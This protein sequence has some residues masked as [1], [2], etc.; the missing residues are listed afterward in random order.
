MSQETVMS[1]SSFL[2]LI[3]VFI[4]FYFMLIRPQKKRE[5]E[6]QMMRKNLEVGDEIVTVGGIIGTI[7]SVKED[8]DYLVI[9]TSADR[10]KVRITRWAVQANITPKEKSDK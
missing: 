8:Q 2:P 4:M 5:K 7:V 10:N 3:L 9:E 1:L 6:T